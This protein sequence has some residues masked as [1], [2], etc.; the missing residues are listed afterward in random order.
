MLK[1][2]VARGYGAVHYCHGDLTHLRH[3]LTDLPPLQ[4]DGKHLPRVW[5]S[6]QQ[7]VRMQ[8]AEFTAKT[9]LFRTRRVCIFA[10]TL[11]TTSAEELYTS[12]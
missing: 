6:S 4:G 5:P 7:P 8:G 9:L 3:L 10:S 1:Q 2:A 11:L 12:V